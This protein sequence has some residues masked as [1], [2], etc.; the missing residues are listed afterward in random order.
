MGCDSASGLCRDGP[1]AKTRWTPGEATAL[2]QLERVARTFADPVGHR[3]YRDQQDAGVR[4]VGSAR[5]GA[6]VPPG[7]GGAGVSG[8]RAVSSGSSAAGLV[9]SAGPAGGGGLAGPGAVRC[10]V[11][12]LDLAAEDLRCAGA[13]LPGG[14]PGLPPGSGPDGSPPVPGVLAGVGARIEFRLLGCFGVRRA[15]REIACSSFGGR[16]V[17]QLVQVLLRERGRVVPRDVLVEAL[18]PE[19]VPADPEANLA[20]LASRARR[21]LGESSLILACQGGYVFADDD[22]CWVDAE[23]FAAAAERGRVSLASGHAAAALGSYRSALAL[24][25]GDPFMENLYQDWAQGYR[26]LFARLYEEALGGAARAALQLGQPAVALHFAGVLTERVPL[27]E[28]G[29]LLVMRAHAE[30]GDPAAAME[31]FHGWRVLLAEELGLDPCAEMSELYGR[32][33]GWVP[34]S[35][36]IRAR[37]AFA[38]VIWP[39]GR[40]PG[41][42]GRDAGVGPGDPGLDLRCGVRA[43]P[44]GPLHVCQSP[45]RG[46]C[47]AARPAAWSA[48]RSVRF[49][50]S[51]GRRGSGRAPAGADGEGAGLL[52]GVLPA[53]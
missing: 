13:A 8:G 45:G 32:I 53:R 2:T 15:G 51:S 43:G 40:R 14:W 47:R 42:R 25:A 46:A 27:H 23:A 28:E 21:A 44:G 49:F 9:G 16:R 1:A 17:R 33:V 48:G 18:W 19:R 52:P 10:A 37:R 12:R 5:A 26:R 22:R 7:A 24:W 31:L 6:V 20:V 11:G 38:G 4:E 41:R 50:L 36:P 35:G 29:Q 39:G 30:A 3:L 34:A